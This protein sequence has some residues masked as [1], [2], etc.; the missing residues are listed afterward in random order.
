MAAFQD[1]LAGG[2]LH[3]IGFK[4]S[5]SHPE[6]AFGFPP[7]LFDDDVAGGSHVLGT[8]GDRDK[9]KTTIDSTITVYGQPEHSSAT[10][11]TNSVTWYS[12]DDP[13]NPKNWSDFKKS[14]VIV[15]LALY[16]FVVYSAAAIW[17]PSTEHV[18]DKFGVTVD[19]ANLGFTLY[20]VG[21]GV[22]PMVFSPISE[23]PR[24]GRNPPYIYSFVLFLIVS[25]VL[26]FINNFPTLVFLRFLQGFFGSPI[27]AS[28][29]GS[30]EDIY[31]M[32][33]APYGYMW[34]VGAMYCGPAL[35]PLFPAWDVGSDWRWPFRITA[36]MAAIFLVLLTFLP[37]TSRSNILLRRA[38]RLRRAF[39]HQSP[40]YMAQSERQTLDFNMMLQG[41]LIRPLE[42][43]AKDPAIAFACIYGA[44]I[45]S[46]YYSFFE[47]FPLVYLDTYGFTLPQMGLIFTGSIAGPCLIGIIAYYTYLK[48]YF[49]PRAR[50]HHC[51]TGTPVPQENWLYPG[52][53]GVFGPPIGLFLFAFT[54][55]HTFHWVVPTVGIGIYITTSFVMF[56]S[57]CC[58][59]ALTYPDYVAS[60]FAANDFTRSMSA[61]VMVS[62]SRW[63]YLNLGIEHGVCVVAGLSLVGVVGM[64]ALWYWGAM[65]RARSSFT[66]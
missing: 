60:L 66:G 27:L 24:V 44:I 57:I 47:A 65:L 25:V 50:E 37:E 56:Q 22:G 30:I 2:L 40:A 29:G 23:I 45:Y 61:A 3:R 55:K 53:L 62:T 18:M 21:Y 34:W 48:L 6:D 58:Y 17:T 7:P 54:A 64:W 33:N 13:T 49:I 63:M 51:A 15:V 4:K 31:D 8:H 41:A 59:V 36:I 46:T 35:G 11:T 42:I 32:Y 28:G 52:M 12:A 38:Q 43:T 16:M 5:L 20:I 39:P 9:E 14:W 26:C 10:G 1:T 19:V